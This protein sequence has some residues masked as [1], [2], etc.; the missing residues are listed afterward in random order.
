MN[1]LD[2]LLYAAGFFEKRALLKRF[3]DAV[4]ESPFYI[5]FKENLSFTGSAYVGPHAY[6]SAKGK[7]EIGNNVI[8]A[9]KSKI[10]TYNHNYDS[11][12]AI[13][14]SADDIVRRVI[15]GDNVWIGLDVLIVPG[16]TIEEGAVVAAGSVVV[17][18]VPKCSVVGGNP[19]RIIKM[20]DVSKYDALKEQKRFYLEMKK[21]KYLR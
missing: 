2:L 17:N 1:L 14:Y 4:I 6:W 18:D 3:P 5:E 12:A 11:D 16:V 19:A 7:I 10:W 21:R 8:I 20:R 15:I 13:P 9:P